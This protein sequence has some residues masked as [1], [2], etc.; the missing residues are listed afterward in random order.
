[1]KEQM[2][3]LLSMVLVV[4]MLM[5]ITAGCGAAPSSGDTAEEEKV[6]LGSITDMSGNEIKLPEK[7]DS[8]AVAWAG[9][10]DILL[11]FDGTEHL[12]AYPEKSASFKWIFDVYPEYESKI[13]LSN[14]GI[15][16]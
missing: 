9:L 1:M 2:K 8:Y 13:C 11:M 3:K 5:A 6:S 7:I 14:E 12:A 15:S 16:S 10:T 4:T